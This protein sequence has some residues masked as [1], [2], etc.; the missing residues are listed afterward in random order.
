MASDGSFVG[1]LSQM[2][3]ESE[4][5]PISDIAVSAWVFQPREDELD[6]LLFDTEKEAC[7]AQQGY[8]LAKGYDPITGEK[9]G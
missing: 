5:Y 8:R 6:D 3:D 1:N 7:A 2:L 4:V 9:E